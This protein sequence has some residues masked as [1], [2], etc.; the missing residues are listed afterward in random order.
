VAAEEP[1]PPSD[2]TPPKRP[3]EFL[4]QLALA[5]ELPVI[6]VVGVF[7]GGGLGYLID[8]R[9]HTGHVFTIL[10]GAIGAAAGLAD[11]IRRASRQD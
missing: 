8:G 5:F 4:R 1:S 10:L 9:I 2:P 3:A 6:P 11:V 7:A